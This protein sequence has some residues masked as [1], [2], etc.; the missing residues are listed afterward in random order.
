M[1]EHVQRPTLSL[2]LPAYNEVRSIGRTLDAMQAWLARHGY[3][4]EIIVS[5]DGDDGTRELV[6]ARAQNDPRLSV[7]GSAE[8]GGK[9]RGIR[10]AV[11]R[12]RGDIIG[13]LDA[14]YKVPIDEIEKILP[15]FDQG[16]DFVFGSRGMG[17]SHIEV[18][19][20]W[21]RQIGSKGFAVVMRLIVGLWG[22][23]D[24]Q[25][26]FKFFRHAVAKDLFR[27][28]WIDGYMFDV[29]ILYLALRSGYRLK[30][31]GITWRDDGDTRLNLVAGNWRNLMDLF[32]IRWA[33]WFRP[34]VEPALPSIAGTITAARTDETEQTPQRKAA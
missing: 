30:E 2:I 17:D 31:V 4:Y 15:W 6:A 32:R 22:I 18:R 28:Q 27:R 26:G 9:G 13:F 8:R 29:E 24:T 34:A 19:P 23:R 20:F 21:Y 5:A 7:L 33:G 3:T 10:L 14:D 25:C 12:A 11:Q 1:A 16:Y